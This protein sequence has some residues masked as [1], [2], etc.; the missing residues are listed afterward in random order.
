MDM[1]GI[2]MLRFDIIG[3]ELPSIINLDKGDTLLVIVVA[4]CCLNMQ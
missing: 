2:K 1:L 3:Y 4:G